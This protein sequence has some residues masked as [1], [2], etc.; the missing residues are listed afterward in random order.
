MQATAHPSAKIYIKLDSGN[1]FSLLKSECQEAKAHLYLEQEGAE[2]SHHA[3]YAEP[4][5]LLSLML[6]IQGLVSLPINMTKSWS[7]RFL[8]GQET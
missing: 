5:V 3:L 4:E 1:H 8:L 7:K 2:T 6:R